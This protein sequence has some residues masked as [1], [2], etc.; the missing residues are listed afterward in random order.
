VEAGIE[1]LIFGRT[2]ARGP[3]QEYVGAINSVS[4]IAINGSGT[5][6]SFLLFK[7]SALVPLHLL[8]QHKLSE[9]VRLV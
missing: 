3:D 2:I 6:S 8:R 9:L 5:V 1:G 4:S 7:L